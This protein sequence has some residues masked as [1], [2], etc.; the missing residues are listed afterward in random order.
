MANYDYIPVK[1]G[2]PIKAWTNGVPVEDMARQQLGNVAG[3]PFVFH[4]VAAMPTCSTKRPAPTRTSTRS[5]P[6]KPIWSRSSTR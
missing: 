6:P 2:V 1:G 5:W 4:H 3:L